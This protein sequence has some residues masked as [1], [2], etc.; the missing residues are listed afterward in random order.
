MADPRGPALRRPRRPRRRPR[1]PR[2]RDVRHTLREARG[3]QSR[4]L[5]RGGARRRRHRVRV[6]IGPV[7]ARDAPREGHQLDHAGGG[8]PLEAQGGGEGRAMGAQG[9]DRL[10]HADQTR[11]GPQEPQEQGGGVHPG[12]GGGE[13]E[14][15]G[16]GARPRGIERGSGGPLAPPR[17]RRRR[18]A[19]EGPTGAHVRR[20]SRGFPRR[21]QGCR[22]PGYARRNKAQAPR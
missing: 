11:E 8:A 15:Q 21:R 6:A 20:R 12:F 7:P 14:P 5:S 9:S 18:R 17:G 13:H 3:G 22:G 19:G 2:P 16:H 4:G 1:R 10:R